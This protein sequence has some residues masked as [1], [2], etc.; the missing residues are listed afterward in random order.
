MVVDIGLGSQGVGD[1]LLRTRRNGLVCFQLGDAVL[2]GAG[3]V[4][5]RGVRVWGHGGSFGR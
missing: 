5:V 1:L 2:V 4:V 3:D